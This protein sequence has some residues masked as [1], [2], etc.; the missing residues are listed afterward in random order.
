MSGT[1]MDS[2]STISSYKIPTQM[3]EERQVEEINAAG[4][5]LVITQE[6]RQHGRLSRHRFIV[7]L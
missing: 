2:S 3:E 4:H 6:A 1:I 5:K 7:W